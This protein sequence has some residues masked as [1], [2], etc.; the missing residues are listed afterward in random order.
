[1][2]DLGSYRMPC[3]LCNTL[4]RRIGSTNFSYRCDT[5]HQFSF[6]DG[7]FTFLAS[8]VGNGDYAYVMTQDPVTGG[9]WARHMPFQ[10]VGVVPGIVRDED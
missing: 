4:A 7:A 9:M 6:Q 1:M 8:T 2:Y 10:A 3:P 5:A